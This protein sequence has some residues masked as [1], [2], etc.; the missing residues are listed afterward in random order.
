MDACSL[1]F[2]LE[3]SC[4]IQLFVHA[5]YTTFTNFSMKYI[6]MCK[7]YNGVGGIK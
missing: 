5:F 7:V 2:W 1:Y 4:F 6:V 3:D